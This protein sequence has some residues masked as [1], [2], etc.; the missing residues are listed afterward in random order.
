MAIDSYMLFQP[1]NG[2]PLAAESQ[3]D[4]SKNSEE[5]ASPFKSNE[6]KVF[7]IDDFSFSVDQ[8]LNIGSQSSGAG[9][10]KINFNPFSIIRKIDK[11]SPT[12]FQMACSG[13]A[14]QLVQLGLRKSAGGET[15]GQM[16]LRFDFKLVAV[17][18][19]AWSHGDQAPNEHVA[20]EYGGLQIR[21]NLQNPDGSMA[22][23]IAGG[24]NKVKNV[25]DVGDAKI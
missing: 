10:G 11:A 21:Y 14:F 22:S 16:F 6:G 24:W 9:A 20:F 2:Q 13:T 4:F 8:M 18:T 19:I 23:V 5:L 12:F 7:E 3:V 15:S 1:Y 25:L 17:K